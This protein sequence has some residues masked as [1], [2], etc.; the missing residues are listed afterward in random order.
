VLRLDPGN[1]DGGPRTLWR[2]LAYASRVVVGVGLPAMTLYYSSDIGASLLLFAIIYAFQANLN[3]KVVFM[4]EVIC[5]AVG[6]YVVEFNFTH[7]LYSPE[8]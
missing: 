6:I 7:A 8:N 5:T 4:Q 3:R 1:A 2:K